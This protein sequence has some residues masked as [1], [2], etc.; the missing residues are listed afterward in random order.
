M[1][2][3]YAA[4]ISLI[5]FNFNNALECFLLYVCICIVIQRHFLNRLNIMISICG[6]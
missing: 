3:V 4:I 6:S 2:N 1:L 5:L